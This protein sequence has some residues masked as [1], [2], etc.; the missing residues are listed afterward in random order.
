MTPEL[1]AGAGDGV[2][3]EV[4]AGRG[5]SATMTAEMTLDEV[6]RSETHAYGVSI[7]SLDGSVDTD[8]G[9]AAA[10]RRCGGAGVAVA[11]CGTAWCIDAVRGGDE[12][13]AGAQESGSAEDS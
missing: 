7:R 1:D 9:G 2:E 3:N 8:G 6:V 12:S 4:S 13:V 5:S 11:G 10:A